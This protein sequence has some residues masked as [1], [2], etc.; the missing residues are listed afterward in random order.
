MSNTSNENKCLNKY[1]SK[2]FR[3]R[4]GSDTAE[5]DKCCK[6]G[7]LSY[8]YVNGLSTCRLFNNGEGE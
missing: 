2:S 1:D 4:F 7:N 5:Y 6:C 8:D 3:E